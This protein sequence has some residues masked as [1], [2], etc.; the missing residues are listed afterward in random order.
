MIGVTID[1]NDVIGHVNRPLKD[2]WVLS[3]GAAA[4]S[5]IGV[6]AKFAGVE[7]Q[8]I[9]LQLTN[10]DGTT[11]TITATRGDGSE[12]SVKYHC[13]FPATH[14]SSYGIVEGGVRVHGLGLNGAESVDLTLA[15]GSLCIKQD[16]PLARPGDLAAGVWYRGEDVFNKAGGPDVH[17]VQH[18]KRQELRYDEDMHDWTPVW[19]GDYILE[20][21]NF[22]EV[23]E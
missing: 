6:P 19:V 13:I 16:D 2:T 12:R 18:Y 21:G 14:F 17:G 5:I 11:Q 8:S 9:A 1:L 22:V 3:G 20:N 4:F 10:S 23:S 15:T 7:I